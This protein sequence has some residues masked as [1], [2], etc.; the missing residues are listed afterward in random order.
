MTLQFEPLN[1]IRFRRGGP[2]LEKQILA[3]TA[4]DIPNTKSH[5][6]DYFPDFAARAAAR[7]A[8]ASGKLGFAASAAL[9]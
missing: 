6:G 2:R 9:K 8:F 7:L 5:W 4:R 1:M 3:R